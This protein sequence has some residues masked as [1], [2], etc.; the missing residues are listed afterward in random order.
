MTGRDTRSGGRWPIA[1][2][3]WSLN[4]PFTNPSSHLRPF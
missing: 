4:S 1:E 2:T 3:H